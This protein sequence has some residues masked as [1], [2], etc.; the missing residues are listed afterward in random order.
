MILLPPPVGG[1]MVIRP[2]LPPAL[3]LLFAVSEFVVMINPARD[4]PVMVVVPPRLTVVFPFPFRDTAVELVPLT[5][6]LVTL[7]VTA[8]D[9]FTL[10]GPVKLSEAIVV[11]VELTVSATRDPPVLPFMLKVPYD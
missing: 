11:A 1:L 7:Y 9:M 2:E 6:R 8:A 5:D 4:A 10:T 3:K